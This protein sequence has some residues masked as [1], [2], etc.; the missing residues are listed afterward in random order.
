MEEKILSSY[1]LY[2]FEIPTFN[3]KS[4]FKETLASN[5]DMSSKTKLY[6]K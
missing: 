2:L 5:D 1:K 4:I 6:V 3:M